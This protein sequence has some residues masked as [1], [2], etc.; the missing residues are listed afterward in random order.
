MELLA[1]ISSVLDFA[2][3]LG[4]ATRWVRGRLRRVADVPRTEIYFDGAD[5]KPLVVDGTP[6]EVA[7]TLDR[8]SG[9]CAFVTEDGESLRVNPQRVTFL[10]AVPTYRSAGF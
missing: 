8:S 9:L 7:G 10:Q 5:S 1:T 4:K 6:E 3:A 2:G